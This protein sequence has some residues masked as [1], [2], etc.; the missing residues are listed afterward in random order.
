M[1]GACAHETVFSAQRANLHQSPGARNP[2]R[3][4]GSPRTSLSARERTDYTWKL[5]IRVRIIY[6]YIRRRLIVRLPSVHDLK[7]PL[8]VSECFPRG[9][10]R[11]TPLNG[12]NVIIT[13]IITLPFVHALPFPSFETGELRTGGGG[14]EEGVISD[15]RRDI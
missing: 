4:R 5:Y 2:F 15:W 14:R 11:K 6:I 12:E 8:S 7:S 3:Q 9:V 10:G 13:A 1:A